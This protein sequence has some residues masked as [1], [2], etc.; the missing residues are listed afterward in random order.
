MIQYM[1]L[2]EGRNMTDR[3][4]SDWI[5]KEKNDL[6]VKEVEEILSWV[7]RLQIKNK[8]IEGTLYEK[9]VGVKKEKI[10]CWQID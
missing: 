5:N 7:M 6:T 9:P 3:F 8:T 10:V 1:H 4:D 2:F